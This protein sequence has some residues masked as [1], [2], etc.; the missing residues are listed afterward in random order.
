MHHHLLEKHCLV[1]DVLFCHITVR[2]PLK[3]SVM[4]RNRILV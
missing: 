2:L 3:W 1:R 4:L